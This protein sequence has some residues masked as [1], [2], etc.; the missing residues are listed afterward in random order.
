M[1]HGGEDLAELVAEDAERRAAVV[2][3]NDGPDHKQAD[4][5]LAVIQTGPLD[6]EF[7][8]RVSGHDSASFNEDAAHAHV[9]HTSAFPR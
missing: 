2:H 8:G 3:P 4:C 9:E 1:D 5:W 6:R 7:Q